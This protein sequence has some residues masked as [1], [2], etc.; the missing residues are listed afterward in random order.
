M[1]HEHH[2]HHPTNYNRA[3][4]LGVILNISF[5]GVEVVYGITAGSL[6]LIADAGHN[7]SDVLSLLLA[8]GASLLGAKAATEKRTYGFRKVTIMASLA[9]SILLLVAIG[10]IA[11]ETVGR[12]LNP[13]AVQGKTVIIVAAVGFVINTLTALLF[14]SG[15]KHDLNIRGAFLHMA[16]DAAVS[17]GVAIAGVIIM[18]TGWL[19]VD[20]IISLL[21]ITVIL[22][23]AWSLLCESMSM[24]IDSVPKDIDL[25]AIKDYFTGLDHVDQFHDLHVWPLSTTE[26]ALSVH[27]VMTDNAL[28][29]G[30]LAKI[31]QDLH[32]RF[33]IE[34]STIQMEHP[35]DEECILDKQRCI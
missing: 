10:G 8:W 2:H 16:A 22:Y 24:A 20:P 33:D 25:T 13:T 28:Q 7:F 30:L 15:H 21:I 34:H 27:L 18:F 19:Y 4:A 1:S 6:A 32:D 26:V 5:V 23:S 35:N 9:S 14:I 29:N 11:W 12:F 3:F 31:Q 17:L